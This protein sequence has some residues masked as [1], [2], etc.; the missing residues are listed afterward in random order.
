[1]RFSFVKTDVA[2]VVK[3]VWRLSLAALT[4]Y[5]IV[6][7]EQANKYGEQCEKPSAFATNGDATLLSQE[8]LTGGEN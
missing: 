5:R 7:Y 4:Q 3:E 2:K 6:S 1:M 8:V